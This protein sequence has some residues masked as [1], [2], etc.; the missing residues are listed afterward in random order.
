[1][2]ESQ[3]ELLQRLLARIDQY[4]QEVTRA[5]LEADLDTW[6]KVSRA[7]ELAA[8]C[9]LDLA[10]E[11]VAKRGLGVPETYRDAFVRLAQAGLI[12]PSQSLALQGWMGLRNV[13]AHMYTTVDLDQ[14]FA[15]MIENKAT[16]RE[17]GR[18]AAKELSQEA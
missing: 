3:L 5:Q 12:T 16:L 2:G 15:A 10:M 18:L 13:L 6:L 4:G 11:I 8:Q 7:L 1:M 14:V 17:F 9:C